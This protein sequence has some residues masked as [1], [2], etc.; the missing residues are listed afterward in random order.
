MSENTKTC[1][2]KNIPSDCWRKFRIRLLENGFDT[3][4][5]A[6]LHLIKKYADNQLAELQD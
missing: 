4:N 2:V 1:L 5:E 3:Y 6:M